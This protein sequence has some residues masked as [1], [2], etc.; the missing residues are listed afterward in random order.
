MSA[1]TPRTAYIHHPRRHFACAAVQPDPVYFPTTAC[2]FVFRL[3]N[4]PESGMAGD[5]G[6][7]M[8]NFGESQIS[9]NR[10]VSFATSGR[11]SIIPSERRGR[12]PVSGGGMAGLEIVP[13]NALQTGAHVSYAPGF[14][15]GQRGRTGG[16][17]PGS[18]NQQTQSP[19]RQ[20]CSDRLFPVFR[21]SVVAG[22]KFPDRRLPTTGQRSLQRRIPCISATR[23]RTMA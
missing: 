12:A 10:I 13:F 7:R 18:H 17:R 23:V 4:I 22:M 21:N 9:D 20:I 6:I 8:G 16:V 15:P 11:Y 19:V 2:R 3:P 1:S 5:A 14:D